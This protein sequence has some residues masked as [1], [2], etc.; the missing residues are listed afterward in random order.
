MNKWMCMTNS[1]AAHNKQATNYRFEL[2]L[3]SE[4][5]L[6]F[7]CWSLCAGCLSVACDAELIRTHYN[8]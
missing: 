8:L 7:F 6:K 4:Q 2:I 1:G 5:K 3:K